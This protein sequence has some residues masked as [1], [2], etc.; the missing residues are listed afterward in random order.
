MHVKSLYGELMNISSSIPSFKYTDIRTDIADKKNYINKIIS[1]INLYEDV[2]LF[3]E[4]L[5]LFTEQTHLFKYKNTNKWFS[6]EP[7]EKYFNNSNESKLKDWLDNLFKISKHRNLKL[8]FCKAFNTDALSELLTLF[9]SKFSKFNPLNL[10]YKY[11]YI[12][13]EQLNILAKTLNKP[14]LEYNLYSADKDSKFSYI[15]N[16]IESIKSRDDI[17][18][19][20]RILDYFSIQTNK[21]KYK[22]LDEWFSYEPY[23]TYYLDNGNE[24]KIKYWLDNLFIISKHRNPKLLFGIA[25]DTKSLSELKIL[26]KNTAVNLDYSKF[27]NFTYISEKQLEL[28]KLNNKWLPR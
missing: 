21:F 11:K 8:F 13:K 20:K 16:I 25:F 15:R 10:T 5:I 1:S 6:Y 18:L 9:N 2:K 26:F 7:Y 19:F 3:K 28:L 23:Q 17:I 22:S 12:T 4:I 27:K 14:L 24:K